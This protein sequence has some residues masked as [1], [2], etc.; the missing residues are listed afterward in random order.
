MRAAYLSNVSEYI[1]TKYE[2][3]QLFRYFFYFLIFFLLFAVLTQFYSR[4]I[5]Q[6]ISYL[7]QRCRTIDGSLT[8]PFKP[9]NT[10]ILY[11]SLLLA[12]FLVKFEKIIRASLH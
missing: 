7:I 5:H 11:S 6:N 8:L 9:H 1:I 3:Q 4:K 10:Q 2:C 12:Y